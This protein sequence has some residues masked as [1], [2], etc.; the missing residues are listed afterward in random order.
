MARESDIP[1]TWG[2][3]LTR[4]ERVLSERGV[5]APHQ[6]AAELLSR[7][8]RVPVPT[9]LAQPASPMRPADT[10]MYGGWVERRASGEALPHITGHLEFMGLDITVG[11]SSPLVPPGAERLV[12]AA[13]HWAR[14]RAPGELLVAEI[15]T[16]CGAIALALAAL[17]PRFIRIYA[18]DAS[19]AALEA[20]RAN[21]ARYL[22]NLVV[23]WLPGERVD[24]VPE[25]VDLIV[26]SDPTLARIESAAEKL[27]PGGAVICT[28][29]LGEEG[30]TAELLA[31]QF[32]G[33]T[34]ELSWVEDPSGGYAIAV[35]SRRL[36][37]GESVS[38]S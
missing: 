5:V 12:E 27:R 30:M 37:S 29:A 25:S 17:E 23:G 24:S 6:D 38:E 28:V 22:L 20:A 4:A 31:R 32:I 16:G 36:D 15:G 18:I 10:E 3:Q 33:S 26:S 1:Q 9:L 7:L 35:A 21:G 14:R 8:L 2:M 13:L 11:Q 34:L 19:P